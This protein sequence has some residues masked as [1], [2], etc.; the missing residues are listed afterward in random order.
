MKILGSKIWNGKLILTARRWRSKQKNK[1]KNTYI[2]KFAQYLGLKTNL[3]LLLFFLF[4][5]EQ[6]GLEVLKGIRPKWVILNLWRPYYPVLTCTVTIKTNL[7]SVKVRHYSNKKY[8]P[9]KYLVTGAKG[10]GERKG[11]RRREEEGERRGRGG[12]KREREKG[13]E[14]TLPNPSPFFPSPPIRYFSLVTHK[15]LTIR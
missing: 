10:G 15:I 13:R 1:A 11:E 8:W 2:S 9:F 4:A 14:L 12:G 7:N 5:P 3:L 6:R